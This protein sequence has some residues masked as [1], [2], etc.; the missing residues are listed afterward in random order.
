[1]SD[2][3]LIGAACRG[4]Q[5]GALSV[6]QVSPV[7]LGRWLLNYLFWKQWWST[8]IQPTVGAGHRSH[9]IVRSLS[10][11]CSTSHNYLLLNIPGP[12]LTLIRYCLPTVPLH[13]LGSVGGDVL[14]LAQWSLIKN[15]ACRFT[16]V[17]KGQG[18]AP[19]EEH[20]HVEWWLI[21]GVWR[22]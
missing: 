7:Q 14:G 20:I 10:V 6:E 1:M 3:T 16:A 5:C 15:T 2:N 22:W 17:T 19:R 8:T 18:Q 21:C 13:P 11:C 9:H 12:G 4:A